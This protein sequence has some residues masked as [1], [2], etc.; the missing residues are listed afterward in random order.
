MTGA[1][2]LLVAVSMM[3]VGGVAPAWAQTPAPPAPAPAAA[4]GRRRERWSELAHRAGGELDVIET[5]VRQLRTEAP[6]DRILADLKQGFGL[7]RSCYGTAKSTSSRP[8]P[9]GGRRRR[10]RRPNWRPILYFPPTSP[11]CASAK[12][13]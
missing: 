8:L 2:A 5:L 10:S 3:A 1:R 7:V 12:K 6:F 4:F 9:R 13:A 11:G